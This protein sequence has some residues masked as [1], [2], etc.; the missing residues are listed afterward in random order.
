MDILP[1]LHLLSP[2]CLEQRLVQS[3]LY[4]D[5]CL[6][7]NCCDVQNHERKTT[8]LIQKN[9]ARNMTFKNF[10][11]DTSKKDKNQMKNYS[12]VVHTQLNNKGV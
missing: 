10:I 3:V 1:E 6:P 4:H 9:G 2:S 11:S 8:G 7:Q 12:T 5:I